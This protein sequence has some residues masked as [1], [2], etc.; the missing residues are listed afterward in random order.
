MTEGLFLILHLPPERQRKNQSSAEMSLRPTRTKQT[1]N[2]S[3]SPNYFCDLFNKV[4]TELRTVLW[5][6]SWTTPASP[7]CT[8]SSA[9]WTPRTDRDAWNLGESPR[10]S[11]SLLSASSHKFCTQQNCRRSCK[12]SRSVIFSCFSFLQRKM[13][14]FPLKRFS[15]AIAPDRK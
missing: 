13:L 14:P 9:R 12:T 15:S 2:Y 6:T 1:A 3:N 10:W 11:Q 4:R 5:G 8:V 7:A